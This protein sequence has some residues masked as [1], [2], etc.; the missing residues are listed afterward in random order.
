MNAVRISL[1]ELR[2]GVFAS[3]EE[4]SSVTASV[5]KRL[6][7]L[8]PQREEAAAE[9]ALKTAGASELA[10]PGLDDEMTVRELYAELPEQWQVEHPGQ[11]PDG[12]AVHELRIG[13]SGDPENATELL[14]QL[15]A[16]LCP[17]IEHS[18]PCPVPWSADF[19]LPDDEEQRAFLTAQYGT[20]PH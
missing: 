12:R 5:R 2:I 7:E 14:D 20:L 6:S 16:T 4:L 3:A 8:V 10:A 9:W 19:T 1:Y 18:G 11:S 17:E 13:V 15:T